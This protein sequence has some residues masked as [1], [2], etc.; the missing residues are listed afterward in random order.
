MIQPKLLETLHIYVASIV[1]TLEK[2][3]FMIPK[4]YVSK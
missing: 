4:L 3:K 1:K 2:G